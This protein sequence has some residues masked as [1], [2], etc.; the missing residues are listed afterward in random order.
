V[1]LG[2]A[3]EGARVAICAR[4][5]S[6]LEQTAKEIRAKMGAEV[7]PLVA[8]LTKPEDAVRVVD[9]T[10]Q[11]FGRLDVL[12]NNAG[13]APGGL[14]VDLTEEHWVQ[15]IQLKLMGYVRCTKAAIP[16]MVRQAGGRIVN[17]VGNNGVKPSPTEFTGTAVSAANLGMTQALAEEYGRYGIRVNAINPGPVNT[18]RWSQL[19]GSLARIKGITADEAQARVDRSI[20]LG[21]VASA[22][23]VADVVVF[24]ASERASFLNGALISVDGGQRKALIDVPTR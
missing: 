12:V 5:A 20:P 8:D 17:I 13:S 7:L 3:R 14:I 10:A 23:E 6:Q 2:L 15:A 18:E 16:H 22:E 11:H 21:R 1:A 4:T 9:A 19:V 24:V